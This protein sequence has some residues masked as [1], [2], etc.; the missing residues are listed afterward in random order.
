MNGHDWHGYCKEH[1]AVIQE[2]KM[3]REELNRHASELNEIHTSLAVMRVKLALLVTI[4]S[5]VGSA[6][7]TVLFMLLSGGH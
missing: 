2:I 7:T 4:A 3:H 5:S 6:I 1:A